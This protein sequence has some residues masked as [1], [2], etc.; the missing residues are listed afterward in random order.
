M[1]VAGWLGVEEAEVDGVM[2]KEGLNP[3]F[4][5]GRTQGLGLGAKFLPH[6]KVR[7]GPCGLT[8]CGLDGQGA[9]R[10]VGVWKFLC[11]EGRVA[12]KQQ[13]CDPLC[14]MH[15]RGGAGGEVEGRPGAGRQ[16]L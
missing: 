15:P 9:S 13:I 8:E 16:Y 6:H 11:N 2:E 10:C 5:A 1:Q 7:R 4:E 3:E 14:T 12:G